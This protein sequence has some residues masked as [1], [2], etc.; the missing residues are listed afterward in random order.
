MMDVTPSLE[1]GRWPVKSVVAEL[2]AV[3][4]VVVRE[5][6]DPVG[7]EVV[8]TAPDRTERRVRMTQTNH[9][10]GVFECE[11][12][13]E[14]AGLWSYRVEGWA[15]PWA[16][17][18]HDAG[19]KVP[20]GIDVELMCEE[21][22]R[23]LERAASHRGQPADRAASLQKACTLLRDQT[24]AASARFA[25]V[26]EGSPTHALMVADPLRDFTTAGSDY[27]WL[28]E[29]K[30][31][32][33]GAWYEIFPRSEGAR[34]DPATGTWHSGTFRTA[35]QRLAAIADMG[36]DVVYLTPIH[37]IGVT[38]RKGWN[39]NTAASPGDPGSP[40][41]IGSPDGGHDAIHPDLGTVKD[42]EHFVAAA[43]DLGLR[44]AMDI[45]L[46]ASPDHPWVTEHPEYFLKRADGSIAFSENPPK[47]YEDIYPINF[48][49]APAT[50]Y[51]EFSR[52]IR[53]WIDRGVKIFRV[54]NPHTKPVEFWQW[55]IADI[56]T[57]HPDVIWLSEAFTRPPLMHV[58][59]KVGFQQSYTYF[60]WRNTAEELT[61]YVS[62]LAQE[63]APFLR[64]SFWPTTHDILTPYMQHGGE[65]AFRIRA[66][67][68]ATLV[69]TYGIYAGY[70]HCENAPR[71]GVEEQLDNEKYGY[72]DRQWHIDGAPASNRPNLA[73]YLRQLN[74]IRR[75]HPSLHWLRNITFHR[76]ADENFL[77]YSKTGGGRDDASEQNTVIV[78]ANLDP[79]H[80]RETT[81]ELDT[82]RLGAH[83]DPT[84]HFEAE[85]LLTGETWRWG[86]HPVYIRLGPDRP[87]HIVAAR[88]L[89]S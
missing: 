75:S 89:N 24:L 15:D 43:E 8:L 47:K 18:I 70:E 19:I 85:D 86:P 22:A 29:E 67:L 41:G 10:L 23:L 83:I 33:T 62:E 46:N 11:I 6:H 65:T 5:G 20:A 74:M 69:P 25:E 34:C 58:L 32:L 35:A 87:L 7:A 71:P 64:P 3:T 53:L 28:V 31:T 63:T 52:I 17:W 68:A 2:F 77:V 88:P 48:D 27:P 50:L 39:N 80:T 4:A 36:F 82:R 51:L 60:A 1:E 45:A 38:N 76:A 72:K 40:Y 42:F 61:E 14:S 9:G 54:D 81:I 26:A 13:A 21:G 78:V 37:P 66:A 73:P 30:L 59:A 57:D 16:A 84:R 55:L 12:S 79:H 44:V 56:A 49:T